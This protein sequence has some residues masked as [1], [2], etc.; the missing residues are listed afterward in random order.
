MPLLEDKKLIKDVLI[1]ALDELDAVTDLSV[2]GK[3]VAG[4][5]VMEKLFGAVSDIIELVLSK[6]DIA[7]LG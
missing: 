3:S 2:T 5:S 1:E 6:Y 4:E 7:E